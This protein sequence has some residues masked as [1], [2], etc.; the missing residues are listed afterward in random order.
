MPSPNNLLDLLKET[1]WEWLDDD[2]F[3]L[4]AAL[5]Y[6]TVFSL[7]PLLIILVAAVGFVWG[8]QS[9]V[10]QARILAE[11]QSVM[12]ESGAELVKTMLEG[13]SRPGSGN[14]LATSVGIAAL[15]F[16]ATTVFAQLQASLNTIWEVEGPSG[17]R[18]LLMS[19]LLSF[20]VI[21]L[22][23]FLLVVLLLVSALLPL[24]NNVLTEIT[25]G[26]QTLIRVAELVISFGVLTLLFGMIYKFLPD[27]RIEW[28]D[29]WMGAAVTALLFTLGKYAF[30]LY[31][32]RASPGSA[33]GA[34]GS[35][36]IL[37]V[38]VYYSSIIIFFGAELTQVYARRRGS[39]IQ[40]ARY[41]GRLH[42]VPPEEEPREEPTPAPPAPSRRKPQPS[43]LWRWGLLA[44]A[45]LLGRL[46]R[47]KS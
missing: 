30:G 3:R 10:V 28:H 47:R 38:W 31:L 33:Y 24:M 22:V 1:F 41:A 42:P 20:G 6:Y 23:G 4:G 27:V 14:A 29:V 17:V 32:G 39:H 12:G 36:A 37:L 18:S 16:G 43:P 26:A 19:R 7:A 44:L 9:G 11:V 46:S 21:L 15:L 25:P 45:F 35:M 2:P 5:A 13:T 34:A 8:Q 40:P